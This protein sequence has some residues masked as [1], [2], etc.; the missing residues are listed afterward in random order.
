MLGFAQHDY[1]LT[2][3]GVK[4]KKEMAAQSAA[5]SFCKI[6]LQETKKNLTTKKND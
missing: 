6:L 1:F 4:A 5:I 3:K 2:G